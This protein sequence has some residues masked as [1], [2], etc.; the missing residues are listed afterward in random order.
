MTW[1]K[2][3]RKFCYFVL[4]AVG[5]IL[6]LAVIQLKAYFELIRL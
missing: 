6:I 3:R 1:I 4:I 2:E 5:I